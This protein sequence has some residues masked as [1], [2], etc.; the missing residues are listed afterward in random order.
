MIS[1]SKEIFSWIRQGVKR[2][3]APGLLPVASLHGK[4][5]GLKLVW[6]ALWAEKSEER[7]TGC[8]KTRIHRHSRGSGSPECLEKTGFPLPQR[9]LRGNLFDMGASI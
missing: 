4:A 3:P 8:G 5:K 7:P 2:R 9:F 6:Q 1:T